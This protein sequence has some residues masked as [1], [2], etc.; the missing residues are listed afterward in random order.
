MKSWFIYG[1]IIA[2]IYA[3][4]SILIEDV[5]KKN[6][7]CLCITLYIYI[8]VGIISLIYLFYHSMHECHHGSNMKDNLLQ[9]NKSSILKIIS[10]SFLVI[11][12][13]IL[14]NYCF[15]NDI[16]VLNVYAM[17]N[18]YIVFFALYGAVILSNK[19]SI[20]NIIGIS[21]VIGGIALL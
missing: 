11:T 21:M 1:F 4:W 16:N 2:I 6:K 13:F 5:T 17:S 3:I 18:L 10:V 7:N 14:L 20:V 19:L 8:L 12:S 15:K 9:F